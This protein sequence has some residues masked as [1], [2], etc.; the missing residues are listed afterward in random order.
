MTQG[1]QPAAAH[2]PAGSQFSLRGLFV[3]L[4]A[5]S[6]MFAILALVIR[7]PLHWLGALGVPVI[8]IGVIAVMELVRRCFPPKPRLVQVIQA[9]ECPFAERGQNPF[10]PPAIQEA[11]SNVETPMSN[12]TGK[13]KPQ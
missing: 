12:E 13:S 5:V 2:R 3:L 1:S 7:S 4:T 8:C 10:G 9:G 6:V 11:I